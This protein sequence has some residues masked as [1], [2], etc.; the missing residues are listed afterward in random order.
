VWGPPTSS[1]LTRVILAHPKCRPI[2]S[3]VYP[4]CTQAGQHVWSHLNLSKGNFLSH[5]MI[6]SFGFSHLI[7]HPRCLKIHIKKTW[8]CHRSI[9]LIGYACIALQPST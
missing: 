6:I 8:M 5:G 4:K 9:H 2:P 3:Q 7:V 1:Q